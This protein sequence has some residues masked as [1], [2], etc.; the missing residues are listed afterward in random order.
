[1]GRWST[2]ETNRVDWRV[3]G[4]RLLS[5]R[6][7]LLALLVAIWP[8]ARGGDAAPAGHVRP[9]TVAAYIWHHLD[10]PVEVPA[11]V[12]R[13]F[14]L[15]GELAPVEGRGVV[16]LQSQ[17]M[18]SVSHGDDV[19]LVYRVRQT[20]IGAFERDP[21]GIR[22]ALLEA[23]ASDAAALASI[24]RAP[25]GL[26][27][28]FDCPTR[29]LPKYA[30]WLE[31]LRTAVAGELSITTLP[32]WR[33]ASAFRSVI[34]TCDFFVAQVYA[35]EL[36]QR[37][38]D[39]LRITDA[40]SMRRWLRDIDHVAR[41]VGTPYLVGLPTYGQVV[42]FD[43]AGR[44][45]GLTADIGPTDAYAA[46]DLEPIGPPLR[47]RLQMEH[48]FAGPDGRT[49][50]IVHITA[51]GLSA[52]LDMTRNLRGSAGVALFRL[53]GPGADLNL[54]PHVIEAALDGRRT[55]ALLGVALEARGAS[56][57]LHITNAGMAPYVGSDGPVAMLGV[58]PP[59]P[60]YI[61]VPLG[62]PYRVE[63]LR[64]GVVV[65]TDAA[66][67]TLFI[68]VPYIGPGRTVVVPRLQPLGADAQLRILTN[69]SQP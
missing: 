35:M 43:A 61:H 55:D 54:P 15:A 3:M 46:S 21:E 48:R 42:H 8:I 2:S 18:Q 29:L 44:R 31:R 1:M 36:P 39:A 60:V 53:A 4:L 59:T 66:C 69:R 68:D 34:R 38:D 11:G 23:Y 45:V 50:G 30:E 25:A 7:V 6:L 22:A 20:L 5:A 14:L 17:N 47:G 40:G 27:V 32:T 41:R 65:G 26:Q 12:G 67:D 51:E 49:I 10:G 56:H 19:T 64:S 33:R 63:R 9:G 24:G 52:M 28:D 16:R 13:I 58:T 62:S 37:K 57:A